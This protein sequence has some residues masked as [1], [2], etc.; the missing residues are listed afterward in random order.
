[1]PLS[2]NEG[3]QLISNQIKE[4]QTLSEKLKKYYYNRLPYVELDDIGKKE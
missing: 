2:D 4:I 1:M 3:V